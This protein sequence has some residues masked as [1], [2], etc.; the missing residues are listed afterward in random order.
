MKKISRLSFILGL[1]GGLICLVIGAIQYFACFSM[2]NELIVA[3]FAMCTAV[4]GGI[5][6]IISSS[7]TRAIPF[8]SAILKTVAAILFL[9]IVVALPIIV[10]VDT[11]VSFELAFSFYP[12]YAVSF[13]LLT[14]SAILGYISVF[15]K[16]PEE[17][18]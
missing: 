1:V 9:V 3:I 13:V 15:K 18:K 11:R 12:F 17:N 14:F 16:F 5:V 7:L 8:I 2:Q 10:N 4:I 6:A